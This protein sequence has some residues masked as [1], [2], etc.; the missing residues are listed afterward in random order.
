MP[1]DHVVHDD[2]C[3]CAGLA[4][5]RPSLTDTGPHRSSLLEHDRRTHSDHGRDLFRACACAAERTGGWTPWTGEQSTWRECSNV[6]THGQCV[7]QIRSKRSNPL[8]SAL[9]RPDIF[10][11]WLPKRLRSTAGSGRIIYGIIYVCARSSMGEIECQFFW[12]GSTTMPHLHPPPQHEHASINALTA[13][14]EVRVGFARRWCVV[15]V[16]HVTHRPCPCGPYG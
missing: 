7:S 3:R 12:L 8:T 5:A 6:L 15:G 14:S 16:Q 11:I 4:Q 2:L 9:S 10:G 1:D 13:H